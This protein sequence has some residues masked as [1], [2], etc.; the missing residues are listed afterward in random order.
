MHDVLRF[1]VIDYQVNA[2]FSFTLAIILL[3][4]GKML[5]ERFHILR[6]YSIPEPVIGGFLCA[7]IVGIIYYTT[8]EK[9]TFDLD[10]RDFLLLYFFAGVGLKS[11]VRLLLAGGKPLLVLLALSCVFILVQ[12]MIGMSVA[13]LFGLPAVTGLMTGSISLV[14]GVG[15][16]LAWAPDFVTRLGV[17]NALEIGM[18]S[19]VVGL[20]AACVIGGPIARYLVNRHR[21]QT[22]HVPA[23]SS[24]LHEPWEDGHMDHFGVLRAWLYLNIALVLGSFIA[25][26]LKMTGLNLPDFVGSLLAGIL[27]RNIAMPLAVRAGI[28]SSLHWKFVR[29]G[30]VL[31]SDICLGMFLTMALMGIQLW[32]LDG[33]LG[34]VSAVLAVQIAMAIVFTVFIVFRCLGKDYEA[35][36]M[37]AGFGGIA[38]GSTATA[39]ANMTAVTASYGKAE[40]AFIVVPLVCGFFIDIVNALVISM[41]A[42]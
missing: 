41:L 7:A 35:A 32:V 34:F 31:I 5:A 23:E 38:L 28:V 42:Q 1:P 12:N 24:K 3:F 36:V 22:P 26:A 18:A 21:L 33:V 9:I 19:N 10:V 14:G 15:T 8:G 16:T 25:A 17:A 27:I 6:Q 37:S 20:I 40:R 39:V 30:L 11:D 13:E 2:F 29:G 4:V